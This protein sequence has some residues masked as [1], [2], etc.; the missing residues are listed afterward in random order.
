MEMSMAATS[1][2]LRERGHDVLTACY[3]GSRTEA[4]LRDDGFE[5]H[6]FPLWGKFHPVKALRMARLV[7]REKIDLVHTD[8]S[9]D[10]FTVV[11]ALRIARGVPLVLHKH[12][13]TFK[14]K[15]LF[16]HHY[17]YP[18][19]DKVIA[20]S[21][22]IRR[23]LLNTH[24]LREDQLCVIHHGIDLERFAPDEERRLRAR[25]ELGIAADELLVGIVGRLQVDK[26]HGE[27]VEVA[28]RILPRIPHARFVIIGE[29]TRGEDEK[30]QELLDGIHSANLGDRLILT[31][32]REDVP[33]LMRALDLFLF[34]T[35]AESFGLVV[36]EAMAAGLPVVS[37]SSDGILDIVKDGETG[38]LVDRRDIGALT[39]VVLSL[40]TDPDRRQAMGRAGLERARTHFSYDRMMQELEDLYGRLVDERGS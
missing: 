6:P 26:G 18:R 40:L 3:P 23:N 2:R 1:A 8:Y 33:D 16:V 10:L 7:R 31:G 22:V 21:E 30:A 39:D 24:P 20:V 11:P 38:R 27:F 4:R 35:H 34:P 36:V 5:P 25:A 17:L 13:G 19:V 29:A 9:R 15:N 32:Y 12:V 14:P 28:R 37:T